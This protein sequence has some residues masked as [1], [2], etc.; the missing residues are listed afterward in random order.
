MEELIPFVAISLLFGVIPLTAI[1]SS[2]YLKSLKIRAQQNTGFYEEDVQELKRLADENED[3]RRRIENLEAIV[4]DKDDS[5]ISGLQ[6]K[7]DK[8]A[9]EEKNISYKDVDLEF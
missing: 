7:E 1:I 4:V 5:M 8:E 3:L 6:D 9:V 2:V